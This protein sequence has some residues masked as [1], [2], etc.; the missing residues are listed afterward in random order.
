MPEVRTIKTVRLSRVI[1][2][3]PDEFADLV[4]TH[5]KLE[6]GPNNAF[7][8]SPNGRTDWVEMTATSVD[9]YS[10]HVAVST[11]RDNVFVFRVAGTEG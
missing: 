6:E 4:N 9:S 10:G 1:S 5:G 3:D 7:T 11:D 8:F 2:K